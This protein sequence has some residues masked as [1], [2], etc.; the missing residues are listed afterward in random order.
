MLSDRARD[1]GAAAAAE[2]I[3]VPEPQAGLLFAHLFAMSSDAVAISSLA[4]G[5]FLDVNGAFCR[6]LGYEREEIIGRTSSELGIWV[7]PEDR[8]A[9]IRRLD[10]QGRA[11]GLELR[12]RT[13]SGETRIVQSSAQVVEV[14]GISHVLL[15]DRD[16]TERMEVEE[17]LRDQAKRLEVLHAID[18]QLL[19]AATL[20]DLVRAGLSRF[21]VLVPCERA[22]VALFVAPDEGLLFQV[23]GDDETRLSD[24][25][26][27]PL[28]DAGGIMELLREGKP[29]VVEDLREHIELPQSLQI[30]R[31]E[32]LRTH[33]SWPMMAQGQLLGTL[34][35]ASTR[36]RA[37]T[38]RHLEVTR[39]I[40][41][42]LAIAITQTRSRSAEREHASEL[43]SLVEKLR[44]AEAGYRT[45]VEQLPAIVYTAEFGSDG[46][47]RYVSPRIEPILGFSPQ[48]WLADPELWFRQLHPDD[49]DRALEQESLSETRGSLDSLLSIACSPATAGRCG[50]ATKP[51]S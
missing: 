10:P 21:R 35:L 15:V 18:R 42:Q 17:A 3:S 16:I 11:S 26:R 12:L 32:G 7:D 48:E 24:G 9:M 36:P 51:W 50:S 30:L 34:N 39:E 1:G 5:V 27:I 44:D 22:S 45:L 25:A 33:A 8:E 13:K 38:D 43:E 28:Q 31:S 14:G 46:A 6:M 4:G 23:D 2:P 19:A 49:R 29:S 41:D 40:A 20:E 37:F 47:W